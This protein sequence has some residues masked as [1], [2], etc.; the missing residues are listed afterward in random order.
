MDDAAKTLRPKVK[1]ELKLV[2][3]V[4]SISLT[5]DGKVSF[6]I[7]KEQFA[8]LIREASDFELAE[9]PSRLCLLNFVIPACTIRYIDPCPKLAFECIDIRPCPLVD[10]PWKDFDRLVDMGIIQK[11]RFTAEQLKAIDKIRQ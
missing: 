6:A 3:E 10:F 4:A 7:S 9:K 11:E 5:E 1:E 8:D 2:N